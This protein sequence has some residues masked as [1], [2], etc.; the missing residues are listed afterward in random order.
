MKKGNN[1]NHPAKGSTI[2]VEPIREIKYINKINRLL[3]NAPRN[4]ALF[5]VGINTSL[6]VSRLLNIKIHQL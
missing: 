5:L 6:K 3:E 2:K 1:I 4:L